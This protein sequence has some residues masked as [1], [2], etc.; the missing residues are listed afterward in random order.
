MNVGNIP[1]L[2]V[3]HLV[4]QPP[5]PDDQN[6]CRWS[7]GSLDNWRH[8]KRC[9]AESA[10]CLTLVAGA[11]DAQVTQEIVARYKQQPSI[12]R[13]HLAIS[14]P[15]RSVQEIDGPISILVP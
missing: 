8:G 14:F 12:R 3:V 9:S 1:G 15:I 5:H 4:E 7:R 2:T 10:S 11:V 6:N 13:F